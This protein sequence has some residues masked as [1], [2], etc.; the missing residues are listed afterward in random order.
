M[1]YLFKLNLL[2]VKT[3]IFSDVTFVYSSIYSIVHF[4]TFI[5]HIPIVNNI[6]FI[7]RYANILCT[8]TDVP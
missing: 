8:L 3:T 4:L 2:Y 1:E 5:L 7:G 6:A